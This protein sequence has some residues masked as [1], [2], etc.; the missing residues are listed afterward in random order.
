MPCPHPAPREY[1]EQV[2]STPDSE[3]QLFYTRWPSQPSYQ[4]PS[5][6]L[7]LPLKTMWNQSFMGHQSHFFPASLNAQKPGPRG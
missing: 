4:K 7:L 2:F 3:V 5:L 1:V 6:S